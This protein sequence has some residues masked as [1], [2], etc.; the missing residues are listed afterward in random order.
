M[1]NAKGILHQD[2]LLFVLEEFLKDTDIPVEKRCAQSFKFTGIQHQCWVRGAPLRR[3]RG[4]SAARELR[5]CG[6][7]ESE[8]SG[9]S[10]AWKGRQRGEGAASMLR[11]RGVRAA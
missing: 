10:A 8:D 6:V 1:V 11:E 4:V 7:G 5:H 3:G 9:V 2:D